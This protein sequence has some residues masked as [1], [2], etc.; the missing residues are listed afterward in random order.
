MRQRS[1]MQGRAFGRR[2]ISAKLWEQ[3]ENLKN[4]LA[5][6]EHA[7]KL[8]E[9]ILGGSAVPRSSKSFAMRSEALPNHSSTWT[10]QA[11]LSARNVPC[12]TSPSM[13]SFTIFTGDCDDD[14]NAA[15]RQ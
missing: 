13:P 14:S 9:G 5:A 3:V 12:S 4:D 1:S 8:N 15:S 6:L 2:T 7:E 11:H 10:C